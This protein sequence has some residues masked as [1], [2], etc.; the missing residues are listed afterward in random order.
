MYQDYQ[1]VK[2]LFITEIKPHLLHRSSK[3][4]SRTLK[5]MDLESWKQEIWKE[6]SKTSNQKDTQILL[7]SF[8]LMLM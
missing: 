5:N 8:N 2:T 3:I 6:K 1:S 7:P 4:Q